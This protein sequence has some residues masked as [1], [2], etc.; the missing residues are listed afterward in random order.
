MNIF[1]WISVASL[2]RIDT[3]E[4]TRLKETCGAIRLQQIEPKRGPQLISNGDPVDRNEYPFVVG[5]FSIKIT[6]TKNIGSVCSGSLISRRHVITAAHCVYEINED[7]VKLWRKNPELANPQIFENILVS[8]GS[9]CPTFLGCPNDRVYTPR[10][11][12]PH[13][14]YDRLDP[15]HLNDVALIEL[16]RDV[17]ET[18]ASPICLPEEDSSVEGPMVAIGYGVDPRR[19]IDGYYPLQKVNLNVI[20]SKD[21]QIATFDWENTTCQGDSGGP[22]FRHDQRDRVV[23]YGI[24]SSGQNCRTPYRGAFN[25]FIDVRKYSNWICAATGVCPLDKSSYK[26]PPEVRLDERTGVDCIQGKAIP[27][28]G[29]RP[30]PWGNREPYICS[31]RM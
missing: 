4:N 5:L 21:G 19:Q 13:P 14:R 12:I 6:S 27:T 17:D 30:F 26:K 20:A 8:V 23:L 2:V 22:L 15:K 11:V 29:P 9:R 25:F 31:V 10:Y 28:F 7:E 1:P 24:T 18:V 3:N 16:D